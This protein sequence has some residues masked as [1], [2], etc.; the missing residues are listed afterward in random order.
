MSSVESYRRSNYGHQPEGRTVAHRLED[1]RTGGQ[2]AEVGR[3]KNR[4]NQ[5]VNT[6]Q[7]LRM[8]SWKR[9]S[10]HYLVA[11]AACVA[12]AAIYA[13]FAHGVSSE[14]MTWAFMIPLIAGSGATLLMGR[15]VTKRM[16]VARSTDN[17][18]Q[19]ARSAGLEE[20]DKSLQH[21]TGSARMTWGCAIAT[22]TIASL[23][24]GIFEIAGT[25]SQLLWAYIAAGLVLVVATM[26]L[27]VKRRQ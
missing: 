21:R 11:S 12:F 5:Q 13:Q 10:V 2:Q 9:V 25:S 24:Q 6:A 3:T 22:F 27:V 14:F 23:L 1:R 20:S 7:P 15:R 17:T 18:D 26:V 4:W 16:V 8:P 19:T